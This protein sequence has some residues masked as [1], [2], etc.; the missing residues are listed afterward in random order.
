MSVTD[1]EVVT[2][3]NQ[4]FYRAFETLD[5]EQMRGAWDEDQA[6]TCVHPGWPLIEGRGEVL[7]S[8]ANIFNNT[9]VMQFT[10]TVA[11]VMVEGDWAWVVCTEG[12]RSVVDGK[13]TEGKIEATNI[14]RKRG[15]QWLLVHHHGSPVM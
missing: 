3:A 4:R 13:V 14:F 2:E 6:V 10:I 5:L 12:L 9:M 11:S 7:Q 1:K 15:E 8:W